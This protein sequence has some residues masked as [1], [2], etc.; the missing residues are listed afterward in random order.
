[1]KKL[2]FAFLFVILGFSFTT[3]GIFLLTACST[4]QSETVGGEGILTLLK[5]IQ[6]M[7]KSKRT[8]L[9]TMQQVIMS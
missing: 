4:S 7:K 6:K 3:G 5:M 1:M 9:L 2:L 8:K